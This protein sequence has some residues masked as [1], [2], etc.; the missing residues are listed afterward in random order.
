[1]CEPLT[2]GLIV[3]TVAATA[4]QVTEAKKAEERAGESAETNRKRQEEKEANIRSAGKQAATAKDLR[5]AA[6]TDRATRA[7]KAKGKAALRSPVPDLGGITSQPALG[8]L[9]LPTAPTKAPK[10][11]PALGGI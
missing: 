7:R 10:S 11:R 8:G 9:G 1:M 6:D 5:T 2:I 4:F 3:T